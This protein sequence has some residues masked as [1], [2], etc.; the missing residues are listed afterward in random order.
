MVWVNLPTQAF[1]WSSKA[2][3][4]HMMDIC[5]VILG[6]S[7]SSFSAFLLR[8]SKSFQLFSYQIP[9]HIVW[10]DVATNDVIVSNQVCRYNESLLGFN[11]E[12]NVPWV[13][14]DCNGEVINVLFRE[15]V[16]G[17]YV[18]CFES[19]HRCILKSN[20]IIISKESSCL[21]S[22]KWNG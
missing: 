16:N 5:F 21:S 7:G 3:L 14:E 1:K 17:N 12:S 4:Q 18:I 22:T 20:L 6:T 19:L 2:L 11:S 9:S 10:I 15:I 8:V 13:A